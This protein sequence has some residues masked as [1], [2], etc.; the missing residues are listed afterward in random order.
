MSVLDVALFLCQRARGIWEP[1][2][3]GQ[4]DGF[5]A[6]LVADAAGEKLDGDEPSPD[7][8]PRC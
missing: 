5:R 6:T 2:Q 8:P 1:C 3:A 4:L 7:P